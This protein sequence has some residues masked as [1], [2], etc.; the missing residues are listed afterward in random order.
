MTKIKVQNLT[1]I[2][3]PHPEKAMEMLKKGASKD[4]IME[5]TKHGVGVVDASFDVDEGEIL[6]VMGLSGSGKSTLIRHINR[7]I[8]PT[9][10]KVHVDGIDITALNHRDL[11]EVRRKKFGMVFQN[12][13]LFPHRTVLTNTEYGL[14]VQG[15]SKNERADRARE[16]LKLVGLEGWEEAKPAQ[17]SGGMQQR[18]GLARA[19]TVDPDILLMDEAFS[20]LDPLIRRD[21]QDELIALQNRVQKTIVFITHDL[22]EALKIGD[23]IVLMKDGKIIQVG[24]GEDILTNPADDYVERFV[25]DVDKSKVL[26]AQSVMSKAR[27]VAFPGDG[28]HVALR[29]MKEEGLSSILVVKGDYTLLG[30]I[31]A[32]D[33]SQ[34]AKRGEKRIEGIIRPVIAVDL[35]MPVSDMFQ[36]FSEMTI[37]AVT[38]Q[39][40]KLKGV[41]VRGA[42]LAALSKNR[43]DF[44]DQAEVVGD[45]ANDMVMQ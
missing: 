30:I 12:F 14:E 33:A 10:G 7:L 28:P 41:I 1:K 27:V 18:V 44:P 31:D 8:E 38:D 42:V 39:E 9:Q 5:K 21:M 25:E 35:D 40:T 17:L 32:D 16:A 37:L 24:T 20:A 15:I 43:P 6:V 34:S 22:D 45:S 11:L 26:T 36:L 19:L 3:G 29:K 2:F 13:G 4:E 23:R